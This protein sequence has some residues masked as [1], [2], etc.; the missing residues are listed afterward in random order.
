MGN[1]TRVNT[2]GGKVVIT[3]DMKTATGHDLNQ[4]I[5]SVM[6]DKPRWQRSE[7]VVD[8]MEAADRSRRHT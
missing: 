2:Y 3:F 7:E 1:T 4:F 5:C 6:N 8:G